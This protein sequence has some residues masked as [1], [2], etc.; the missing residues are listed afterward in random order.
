MTDT[1]HFSVDEMLGIEPLRPPVRPQPNGEVRP[2]GGYVSEFQVA[3]TNGLSVR[4]LAQVFRMSPE[5]VRKRLDQGGCPIKRRQGNSYIYDLPTAAAYLVK[6]AV[7]VEDML[8]TLKKKDLPVHLQKDVWDARLKELQFMEKARE[9]WPG[10]RVVE[11]LSEVFVAVKSAIQLW[12]DTVER[13]EGLTTDQRE[14][15]V[16]L[17]DQLQND[18]Y[19]RL[20]AGAARNG[21]PSAAAEFERKAD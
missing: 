21:T 2:V 17:G 9:L 11:I 6:P 20:Q 7:S 13:Q 12:P 19:K 14:M 10:D 15:L 4:Q 1:D 8:R 16:E 18:I 3:L 5:T